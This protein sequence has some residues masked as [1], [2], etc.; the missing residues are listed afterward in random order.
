[1][2]RTFKDRKWTLKM[3]DSGEFVP[4]PR[5]YGRRVSAAEVLAALGGGRVRE[6][7]SAVG[8]VERDSEVARLEAA[9]FDVTVRLVSP[10]TLVGY[11]WVDRSGNLWDTTKGEHE[12]LVGFELARARG[13]V[14]GFERVF[15]L[16]V[17]EIVGVKDVSAAGG[18]GGSENEAAEDVSSCGLGAECGFDAGACGVDGCALGEDACGVDGCALGEDACG[19][20]GGVSGYRCGE[21]T[22]VSGEYPVPESCPGD[23]LVPGGCPAASVAGDGSLSVG[24]A[25]RLLGDAAVRAVRER[26]NEIR[27][28]YDALSDPDFASG[29]D[30]RTLQDRETGRVRRNI[31][32]ER[33]G[34]RRRVE[35]ARV[36][37]PR[38]SWDGVEARAAV[39]RGR[40]EVARALAGLARAVNSGVDPLDDDTL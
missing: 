8:E 40:H 35:P 17:F 20:D 14:V 15:S 21:C 23:C 25:A 19:V 11:R 3:R 13:S 7:T 39:R 28:A 5:V 16:P 36:P 26:G 18:R 33:A 27:A 24:E 10:R 6:A 38:L 2:S 4:R 12:G 1:M 37:V 29:L 9:G 30:W 34:S 32:W 22:A 31:R